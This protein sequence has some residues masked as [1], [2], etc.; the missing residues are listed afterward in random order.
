MGIL[1]QNVPKTDVH[2]VW[3]LA[4]Q[5]STAKVNELIVYALADN[6]EEGAQEATAALEAAKPGE[7]VGLPIRF[8]NQPDSTTVH[9]QPH[10]WGMW[11]INQRYLSTAELF[12]GSLP[13]AT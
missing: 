12:G 10:L 7:F 8:V 2:N 6:T 3:V 9:I 4:L 5:G 11:C 13:P 1:D